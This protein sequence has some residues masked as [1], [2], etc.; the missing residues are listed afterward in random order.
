MSTVITIPLP[1][2]RPP[3]SG[4]DRGHT[5]WRASDVKAALAQARVAVRAASPRPIVGAVVTLHWQIDTRHRRD[6]DNM[7]PTL[8]E[9]L[10]ALVL[11]GVLPDDSW[12]HV[13]RSGNEI[14]PPRKGIPA[15]MW[16]ELTDLHECGEVAR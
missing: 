4:N 8:K 10:D 3:L 11:E 13:I 9:C 14:H 15:H 6:A 12:V 1:W 2:S 5:R 16:L 7:N